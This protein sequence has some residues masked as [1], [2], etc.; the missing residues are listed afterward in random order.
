MNKEKSERGR[1]LK[2]QDE[3]VE[4]DDAEL[5]FGMLPQ[6][7][8]RQL[9]IATLMAFKDFAMEAANWNLSP[10]SFE[11]LELLSHN[12]G[13]GHSRLAAAIGLEKSSLVPAIARL[14]DLALVERK[15]SATDKRAH[16]L[17]IT[18]KG[19]KV[20]AELRR[21][22]LDRDS[23]ITKGMSKEDIANLN[24]LLKKVASSMGRG[25]P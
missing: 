16:E 11:I 8:A 5:E 2:G 23:R 6:L 12:P 15:Q 18:A 25:T 13:L 17:R 20:L 3:I 22:I 21:Y 10:G 14:E 1:S 24:R 4:G 9:R 7:I 19:K